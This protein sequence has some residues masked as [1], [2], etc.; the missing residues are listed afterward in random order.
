MRPSDQHRSEGIRQRITTGAREQ[1]SS[2]ITYRYSTKWANA[3]IHEK[4]GTK[5]P[6]RNQ[7]QSHPEAGTQTRDG[8]ER[9]NCHRD[10]HPEPTTGS[11]HRTKTGTSGKLRPRQQASHR[12]RERGSS[13]TGTEE[14][15]ADPA[16]A[17]SGGTTKSIVNN[18]LCK[19]LEIC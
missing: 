8:R 11:P 1:L 14:D 2:R 12:N 9:L 10:R 18:K 16:I 17:P 3:G 13:R 15:N 6:A 5:A 4:A 7:L 19:E